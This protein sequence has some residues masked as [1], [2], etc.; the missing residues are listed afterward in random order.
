MKKLFFFFSFLV[1]ISNCHYGHSGVMAQDIFGR[2]KNTDTT[3]LKA[4]EFN[5]GEVLSIDSTGENHF[6]GSTLTGLPYKYMLIHITHSAGLPMLVLTI[7][8]NTGATIT[9]IDTSVAGMYSFTL[10]PNVI[11]GKIIYIRDQ[12]ILGKDEFTE[13]TYLIGYFWPGQ[14]IAN[15]YSIG[16][17]FTMYAVDTDGSTL[18]DHGLGRG[19]FLEIQIYD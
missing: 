14:G 2:A 19:V 1:M 16:N 18:L 11:A 7:Y 9:N 15:Q 3:Y 4:S 12:L 5:H 6:V 13:Q 17:P 8:N 10:S